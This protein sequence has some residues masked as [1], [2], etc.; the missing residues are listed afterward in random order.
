MAKGFFSLGSIAVVLVLL[1]VS[2]QL[3]SSIGGA[4]AVELGGTGG[5]RL[6]GDWK[7]EQEADRVT[8]P[9]QPAVNFSQYAGTVT[10]DATAGRAYFYFLV[11][12]PKHSSKKPLTLWL[13]GGRLPVSPS[14]AFSPV[15][16]AG[17]LQIQAC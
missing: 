3:L 13:N 11:E 12:S 16:H 17:S 8:L 5:R 15:F 7:Q 1:A 10:V 6:L 2:F 14:L 9:E 4:E